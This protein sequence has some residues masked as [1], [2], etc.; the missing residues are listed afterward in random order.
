VI[1]LAAL[2]HFRWS[3]EALRPFRTILFLYIPLNFLAVLFIPEA[4]Q[5]EFPAWRGLAPT[6]NNL[7]QIALL[8]LILW[9]GIV[10]YHRHRAI[11]VLHYTWLGMT[12]CLFVGARST[13]AFLV[14]IVL[15]GLLGT[16]HAGSLLKQPMVARVYAAAL[17][18]GVLVIGAAVVIGAPDVPVAFLSLFGKDMTFTGRVDLWREVLS[19][20]EGKW[21]IG[22]GI[23]G[24][25]VMDSP[26]LTPLFEFFPWLPNQAHQGYIDILNQTGIVGIALL[27]AAIAAYFRRLAQLEKGQIWKWVLIGL[28]V[29]NFQESVFFRPRHIGHFMFIFSYIALHVDLLKERERFWRHQHDRALERPFLHRSL[30]SFVPET[31]PSGVR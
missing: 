20:M 15:L 29:L 2:L 1:C 5:W 21:M 26:H 19:M 30:R 23:G 22:W 31:P 9:I 4:T 24:F 10:P 3:E 7:G 12:A 16:L 18:V 6:K 14:G 17:V 13:T 11:N 25:W 27:L 28:L 8:S